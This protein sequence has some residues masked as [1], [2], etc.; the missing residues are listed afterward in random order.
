VADKL[1][2]KSFLQRWSARKTEA[3]DGE[4]V[5]TMETQDGLVVEQSAVADT[6]P[7]TEVP[8]ISD[9]PPPDLPDVETLNAD[10]DYTGFL[11]ENVPADVAKMALRKLW[12]SDPVLANVDGLNDY[13]EDFSKV[14]MVSEVVKTAYR[15]GKGYLTD[16]EIEGA[17]A[18]DGEDVEVDAERMSEEAPDNAS[19]EVSD[20]VADIVDEEEN[21]QV[22]FHNAELA[23]SV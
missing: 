15:I 1:D 21:E 7:D 12:R 11:G 16:A 5:D 14:G 22:E 3:R 20:I 13:D 23:K 18:E 19:E 9:Q 2:D 4:D 10:S 17:A 8:D 6:D